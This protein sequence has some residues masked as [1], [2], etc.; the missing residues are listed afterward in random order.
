MQRQVSEMEVG[1]LRAPWGVPTLTTVMTLPPPE[2]NWISL[3]RPTATGMSTSAAT[4]RHLRSRAGSRVPP[5]LHRFR[6]RSLPGTEET[7]ESDRPSHFAPRDIF[8]EIPFLLRFVITLHL[9]KVGLSFVLLLR[10]ME[11]SEQVTYAD[12]SVA[13]RVTRRVACFG[14]D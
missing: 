1:S 6:L 4:S 8:A 3:G 11:N 5:A 13:A 9:S 7:S 2:W 10:L 14:R 12:L